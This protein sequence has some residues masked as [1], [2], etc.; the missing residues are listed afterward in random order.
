MLTSRTAE[1]RKSRRPKSGRQFNRALLRAKRR[2]GGAEEASKV[3]VEVRLV[4]ETRG[5]CDFGQ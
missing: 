1:S 3:T 2:G 5:G 4:T